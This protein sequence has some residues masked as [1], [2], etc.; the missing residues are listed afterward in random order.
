MNSWNG[1]GHLT[2]DPE[3][4]TTDGGTAICTLRIAIDRRGKGRDFFDVK[5][6]EGQAHA[7]VE[8]LAKGRQ[9]AVTGR[10]RFEEFETKKGEYASRV[11]V[12]ADRVE[13]LGRRPRQDEGSQESEQPADEPATAGAAA[14]CAGPS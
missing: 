8:H 5:C 11:Y 6:F 7:C 3:L 10:L 4:V 9:V 13:F 12:V 14:D 1:V 2:R